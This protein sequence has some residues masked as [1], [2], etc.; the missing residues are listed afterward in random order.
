VNRT[1]CKFGWLDKYD[2]KHGEEVHFG[3]T[4]NCASVYIELAIKAK[5]IPLKINVIDGKPILI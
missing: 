5:K 3:E 2:V 1:S 4:N